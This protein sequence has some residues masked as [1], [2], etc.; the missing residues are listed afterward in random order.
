VAVVGKLVKK[1]R[2]SS[3][4]KEKKYT[5]NTKIQ[6]TQNRKQTHKTRK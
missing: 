4:Q 1:E 5:K 6:N 2:D 3:I